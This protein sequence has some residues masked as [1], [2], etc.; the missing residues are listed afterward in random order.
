MDTN[1]DAKRELSTALGEYLTAIQEVIAAG[2]QH[3]EGLMRDIISM[4]I[5]SFFTMKY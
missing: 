1:L 4:S 3:L 2:S 5:I